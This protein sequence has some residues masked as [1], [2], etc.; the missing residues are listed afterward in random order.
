MAGS[1]WSE[2]LMS[3]SDG[4]YW[5]G[6]DGPG[7]SL[8]EFVLVGS[9]GWVVCPPALLERVWGCRRGNVG[10]FCFS[11]GLPCNICLSSESSILFSTWTTPFIT[12]IRMLALVFYMTRLVAIHAGHSGGGLLGGN[13]SES[14]FSS[15][16][17]IG[18]TNLRYLEME[19][20]FQAIEGDTIFGRGEM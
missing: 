11:L 12:T 10:N 9:V 8:A 4:V 16:N 7:P 17:L 1:S 13:N 14:L 20:S 15:N 5:L 6:M 19:I 2:P 3:L 18:M